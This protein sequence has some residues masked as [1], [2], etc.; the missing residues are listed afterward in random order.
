MGPDPMTDAMAALAVTA[1]RTAGA[2]ATLPR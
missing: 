1:G 2:L